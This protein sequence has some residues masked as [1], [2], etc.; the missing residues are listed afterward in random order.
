MASA[1]PGSSVTVVEGSSFCLSSFNGDVR[2]NRVEGLFVR[3]TRLLSRWELLVDGSRVHGLAAVSADPYEVRFT[4]RAATRPGQVEPTLIVERHRLVGNGLRED[5]RVRNFASEAAAIDLQLMVDADFADVFEVKENRP[6]RR[7]TVSHSTDGG[8]LAFDVDELGMHRGVRITASDARVAER[9]LTIAA[10]VPP[11]GEWSTSIEVAGVT[12]GTESAQSFPIGAALNHAEPAR[13]MR[14]WRDS[15]PNITVADPSL[16]HALE[17]SEEDLGALRIVDA[18]HPD[19]SV[20]AA[21]APWFMA[22]FGRDSLLTAWMTLP[23]APDLA[24]GTLRTLARLQGRRVDA[25]TEEQPGRILHEVRLGINLALAPGGES[26]YYGSIDATPLFVMLVGEALRWGVPLPEI[27][28]LLPAVDA[29]VRWIV[30]YGDRDGDG[31]VEY[32][33]SSDRGLLNQ[34]WKDSQDAIAG[35]DGEFAQ[36][37]I[38][39]AEVQ[40]YCYAAFEAKAEIDARLGHA[41]DAAQWRRRARALKR[42]FHERFWMPEEQFYALA[43]D[44]RK[45]QVDAIASNAGQCLWTGIVDEGV[46]EP[47]VDRLLSPELFSG[48]GIRTLGTGNVRYNPV[49]YHNGSVWPHDTVLAAAGIATYGFDERARAVVDGLID[50]SAAFDGRLPELFCGFDRGEK[51]EPVPYPASCSPQAWA[52]ATPIEILRIALGLRPSKERRELVVKP[53][54]ARLGAVRIN[55]LPF[56][57]RQFL[58]TAD[59]GGIAVIREKAATLAAVGS[60]APGGPTSSPTA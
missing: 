45:R 38:A 46:A 22:L 29:A 1:V 25:R 9:M 60:A 57:R 54:A 31:L 56:D 18:E 35:R 20:V 59:R 6:R 51:A 3:D 47:V 33:R 36:G 34:G 27:E 7:R 28:P 55:N 40:G 49:S 17:R 58:L 19:D 2:P 11:R 4:G 8:R 41:A 5:I 37:P 30:E 48:F 15:V 23:F 16:A 21:G 24:M 52:S 39:L 42:R 32:E 14:S 50:A 13:R 10:V 12:G 26:A 44:G 43:L 53:A